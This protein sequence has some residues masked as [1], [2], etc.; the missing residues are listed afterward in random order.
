MVST[1][2][3][4]G[5]YNTYDNHT[6]INGGGGGLRSIQKHLKPIRNNIQTSRQE[7]HNQHG[8]RNLQEHTNRR[9]LM[10]N[11][12]T[13]K[14]LVVLI[15]FAD[16][17]NRTLPSVQD[18]DVLLNG[19]GG[20]GTVAPSGSVNDV[21]LANSYGTFS[22]ESIIYPTWITVSQ[23]ESYYADKKSGLGPAMFEAI[24]EALDVIDA[25]PNFDLSQFNTDYNQ[26]DDFI[27]AITIIHSGYGAE[28]GG[29][30][31]YGNIEVNRIWSHSW[32][33]YTGTWT[34]QDGAVSV[35]N[36]HI[37]PGL[38]GVCGSDISRIGVIAHE[39]C[40]FLGLPDLYDPQGGNGIGTY[41][42]MSDSWGI[43]ASQYYP[44][45]LSPWSKIEL[46][47]VTPTTLETSGDF[48]L[49][50]SWQ[51][52]DIYKIELLGSS[53]EYLLIENRQ[54]GSFD[55]LL[56][57]GG[58]A[59]WHIDDYN[60][61]YSNSR[62]GYPGQSGWPANNLHYHVALLQADGKYDLEKGDNRG[63]YGDLFRYDAYFG[64]DHLF[65][66]EEANPSLGPFPNTDSY[67]QGLVTRTN[68]F[69][70]DISATSP[71]MTFSFLQSSPCEFD[72]VYFELLL[73]VDGNGSEVSWALLE[74]YSDTIVLSGHDYDD[75]AQINVN[76]CLPRKCYTFVMYDAGNDGLCCENGTGGYSVRL[77]GLK[78]ASG[79][80]YGIMSRQQLQCMIPPTASPTPAPFAPT[81]I[82]SEMPSSTPSSVPSSTPTG[83]CGRNMGLL[84][85]FVEGSDFLDGIIWSLE[86]IIGNSIVSS[87][88]INSNGS[89]YYVQGCITLNSCYTFSIQDSIGD[90]IYNIK[91]DGEIMVSGSNFH[92][93]HSTMFGA[94]CLQ[95]NTPSEYN[96]PSPTPTSAKPTISSPPSIPSTDDE[97]VSPPSTVPP[98]KR[99]ITFKPSSTRAPSS[100][101][102]RVCLSSAAFLGVF[103]LLGVFL[104]I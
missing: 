100:S 9:K 70:S 52:P 14:N 66:S 22:L 64:V 29:S 96:V 5:E 24:R 59:I 13:L 3:R 56:G 26:G 37:N 38:W 31:C 74:T 82:P 86:D 95:N 51:Y 40:H 2:I 77:N 83:V 90:N 57:L 78:V 46:G 85:I 88:D 63:D 94:S 104:P 62:E 19:P 97:I 17:T 61:L 75:H 60:Q 32:F 45:M 33:M 7:E 71:E 89:L 20:E 35:S 55:A 44:P 58:L 101:A 1:G 27:D 54:P 103:G 10:S 68:H 39:T 79:T 72:E 87:T 25:D 6:T 16:H 76:Q 36:Y 98:N 53:S 65:P 42:L 23:T 48:T 47:W 50:Q 69:I 41:C 34:S 4:F 81:T 8:H 49:R 28:F 12:N 91:L 93:D 73:L 30:D 18:Y 67:R 80:E 84:E 11:T 102:S 21:F 99:S 15:R 92:G 43:D